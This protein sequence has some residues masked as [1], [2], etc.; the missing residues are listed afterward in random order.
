MAQISEKRQTLNYFRSRV[1]IEDADDGSAII[2]VPSRRTLPSYALISA[3]KCMVDILM[4]PLFPI[5]FCAAAL[6]YIMANKSRPRAI[7]KITRDTI[8][9]ETSKDDSLGRSARFASWPRRSVIEFRAHRCE[10]GLYLHI[11]GEEGLDLLGDLPGEWTQQI[12]SAIR[13]TLNRLRELDEKEN[14]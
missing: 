11:A 1:L 10:G 3:A 5:I 2:T 8:S 4:I 14:L 7:L 12:D 6:L 9:L 13:L